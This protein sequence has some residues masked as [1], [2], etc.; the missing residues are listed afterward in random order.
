[1]DILF[2]PEKGES[3]LILFE[4]S[5]NEWKKM[6]PNSICLN[7]AF[8]VKQKDK[9]VIHQKNIMVVMKLGII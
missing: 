9:S 4:L 1:M 3:P 2:N 6:R 5:I 7:E 8:I